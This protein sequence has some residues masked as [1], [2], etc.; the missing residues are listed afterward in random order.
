MS[1]MALKEFD[2]AITLEDAIEE[3]TTEKVGAVTAPTPMEKAVDDLESKFSM[4]IDELVDVVIKD[5][6]TMS[7]F[8]E[9]WHDPSY[10]MD[11]FDELVFQKLM[12]N[13][14]RRS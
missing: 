2:I 11:K 9:A 6:H 5:T 12:E 10:K 14:L 13:E 4:T 3:K 8:K 7:V 1:P